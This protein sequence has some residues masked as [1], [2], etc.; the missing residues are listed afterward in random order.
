MSSECTATTSAAFYCP[1]FYSTFCV[2]QTHLLVLGKESNPHFYP[3]KKFMCKMLNAQSAGRLFF[4]PVNFFFLHGGHDVKT[5][6]R[7]KNLHYKHY[8]KAPY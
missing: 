6:G 1:L 3:K 7:L 5:F 8:S 2:G 4:T